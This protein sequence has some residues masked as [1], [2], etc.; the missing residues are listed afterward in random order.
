V[1]EKEI[2]RRGPLSDTRG[3]RLVAN[4]F[5]FKFKLAGGARRP[6]PK[7]TMD[8]PIIKFTPDSARRRAALRV[9]QKLRHDQLQWSPNGMRRRPRRR[10]A[11]QHSLNHKPWNDRFIFNEE[12]ST[13]ESNAPAK[14]WKR[15]AHGKENNNAEAQANKTNTLKW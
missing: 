2:Y 1:G 11:S 6:Q 5:K 4:K 10:I 14:I 9:K 13:K 7:R 15:S 3:M 8:P 12:S